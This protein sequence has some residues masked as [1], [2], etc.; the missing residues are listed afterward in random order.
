[1]TKT[2]ITKIII[3]PFCYL[4][5]NFFTLIASSIIFI[6]ILINIGIYS[7]LISV[8]FFLFFFLL[9]FCG[10]FASSLFLFVLPLLPDI[11]NQLSILIPYLNISHEYLVF[12]GIAGIYFATAIKAFFKK[13]FTHNFN[14]PWQAALP[15]WFITLSTALSIIRNLWQSGNT[16]SFYGLLFNIFNFPLNSW[17]DA[18]HPYT[19][20]LS[21]CMAGAFIT[22]LLFHL[23][24]KEDPDRFIFQ[25]LML[26]L[27]F[28]ACW[29]IFQALTGLGLDPNK[30]G[31]GRLGIDPGVYGFSADI[32]AYAGLML[33]GALGLWAYFATLKNSKCRIFISILIVICWIALWLSKSRASILIAL[34]AAFFYFIYWVIQNK[35]NHRL[36]LLV[37]FV[38][39]FSTV[40]LF[41]LW[42]HLW[43]SNL[44]LFINSLTS[45]DSD[46]INRLLA[47]RP[48]FFQAALNMF[49]EYPLLGVGLGNVYRLSANETLSGSSYLALIGGENTHNYFLQTLAELGLVGACSLAFALLTPLFIVSKRSLTWPAYCAFGSLCL[50]NIFAHSFLVRETLMIGASFIALAY[51]HATKSPSSIVANS[52]KSRSPFLYTALGVLLLCAVSLSSIEAYRSFYRPPFLFGSQCYIDRPLTSDNWTS[53][54]FSIPLPR[55]K[56]GVRLYLSETSPDALIRPLGGTLI[57]SDSA[58]QKIAEQYVLWSNSGPSVIEVRLDIQPAV[59]NLMLNNQLQAQ[60]KLSRCFIPR[61]LGINIDNRLLGVRIN[62]VEFLNAD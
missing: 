20:W 57:I 56:N 29:G 43:L 2:F 26:G 33:L 42:Q 6:H 47:H 41:F 8:L 1:M 12:K 59:S 50:G 16:F 7:D 21:Y 39:I 35:N 54:L 52:S 28:S 3:S 23:K 30:T 48:E 61:N 17:H 19:V 38:C 18:Y 45:I 27:F 25:P 13:R 9:G 32:H 22:T 40:S 31:G 55:D 53:G 36:M 49:T 46:S 15:L 34:F 44:V 62:R 24:F 37:G 51:I 11:S 58:G 4:S 5:S 60:L 14:L 10:S